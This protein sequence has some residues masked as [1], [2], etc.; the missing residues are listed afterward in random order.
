MRYTHRIYSANVS[1]KLDLKDIALRS[2]NVKYTKTPFHMLEWKHKKIGGTCLVYTSGKVMCHGDKQ[3][4]R[5][6]CRVIQKL[7]YPVRLKDTK[8]CTASAVYDLK[9]TVDYKHLVQ[10][11][12]QVSFHPELFHAPILKLEQNVS[13][14]IFHSGKI[15]IA[16]VTS[17]DIAYDVVLPKLLEMELL[18][19]P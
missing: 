16:G 15:I 2:H 13:M 18:L 19:K 9:T 14:T 10:K 1:C 4:M 11:F 7:G 3:M 5:K 6:Y 12:P 17:E 8:L